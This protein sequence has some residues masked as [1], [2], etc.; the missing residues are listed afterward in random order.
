MLEAID[1]L[2]NKQTFD[3]VD[4]FIEFV[5]TINPD[6]MNALLKECS[7]IKVKRLFLWFAERHNHD[8]LEHIDI[9]AIDLG[10]GKRQIFS[11]GRLDNKYN[12]TVPEEADDL[13]Y[14]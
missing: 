11:N 5:V 6:R 12:I 8:W 13:Y 1:D 7:S 10:S 3:E 4:K 2:P 9:E 14:Y